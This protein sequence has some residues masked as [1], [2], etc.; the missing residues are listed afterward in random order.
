MLSNTQNRDEIENTKKELDYHTEK[1]VKGQAEITDEE[2]DALESKYQF[3]TGEKYIQNVADEDGDEKLPFPCGS[4]DKIK[5]AAGDKNLQTFLSKYNNSTF[6]NMD[7]YDGITIIVEYTGYQ[8]S[9]GTYQIKCWKKKNELKG[10]RVDYVAKYSNFPQLPYRLL[11]RGELI[12]DDQDF[13]KLK[14]DLEKLG[15]KASHPRNIVNAA[16]SRVNPNTTILPYCKFIPYSLYIVDDQPQHGI[17]ARGYT[18]VEQLEILKSLTF[19]PAPYIIY[20]NVEI[21]RKLLLEYLDYRKQN[22]GYRIDG[23][24]FCANIP[25]S[26]PTSGENPEYSV[27][28]KKDT[29]K[30]T[31]VKG[32]DFSFESKDGKLI[33]VIQVDPTFV[34]TEVTNITMYNGKQLMKS[35]ITKDAII[36]IT[37]GGDIIPKFLWVVQ[38]GDNVLFTP[39]IPWHWNKTGTEMIADNADEYP[40][41]RCAK[42]KYFLEMLGVKEWGLLTIWKLYHMG[43]TD[44]DKLIYVTAEQL[45]SCGIDGIKEK[46]SQNLV[47]ELHRGILN[48]N[49]AKVMAGSGYFDSGLAESM[50]QKFIDAFPNWRHSNVTYEQILDVPGFGPVRATQISN[51]LPTFQQWLLTVPEFEKCIP[52]PKTVVIKS[53]ALSGKVFYFTGDKNQMLQEEIKSFGGKVEDN[54]VSSVNVVVRKDLSFNSAKTDKAKNSNGAITLITIKELDTYLRQLR[55]SS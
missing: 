23:T 15:L 8:L 42:M 22:A 34:I 12:I 26:L 36:A 54:M 24:I 48:S 10:P 35:G 21:N 27:A 14:P 38:P 4:Q 2:F 9:D 44:L 25:I 7:K 43:M 28:I 13:E 1:Y 5:D 55:M 46:T 6:V 39:G 50:M 16:T 52:S 29:I 30:F 49:W 41:V 32:C 45:L 19:R 3:L 18:Q 53:H 20:T 11:I 47:H 33:P 40:Q 37:Q 17:T 31:R 51:G